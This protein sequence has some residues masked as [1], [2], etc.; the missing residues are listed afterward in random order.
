MRGSRKF[1]RGGGGGG[2][3]IPRRGL[4]ENFNMAK[5]ND[6]AIQGGGGVRT[7]CPPPTS[8][9]AH[10]QC[11]MQILLPAKE[12]AIYNIQLAVKIQILQINVSWKIGSHGAL[13]AHQLE[14]HEH[15][16]DLWSTVPFDSTSNAVPR[17]VL[18]Y[19]YI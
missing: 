16:S 17:Y 2:Y 9:S 12:N 11:Q 4:T 1:S 18:A 8:G 10:V 19:I 13:F 5:I 6:L 3:Q 15:R 14:H 7:P